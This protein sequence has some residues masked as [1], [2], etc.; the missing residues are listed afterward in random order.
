MAS[1][2][3]WLHGE[4]VGHET[5]QGKEVT[6]STNKDKDANKRVVVVHCK[7]GKG[8]SG[9]VTCSYLIS[10]CGWKAEDAL[11]R[12][13]ERRM[14]PKFGAG[15]SIPSQLRWVSYVDRWTKGGKK[16]VDREIEILEVHVWGLRHG[17]KVAIEGFAEEGKKMVVLHTFNK[18]ERIIIQ[19]DAPG[20]AGIMDFVGDALSPQGDD[21]E[22][23]K[24]E[25]YKAVVNG[26]DRKGRDADNSY[27][28][29]SSASRSSSK[30]R[31]RTSLLLQRNHNSKTAPLST[32][33]KT[34]TIN[35]A[36]YASSETSTP[37]SSN[38]H[39]N[40]AT[41]T[42]SQP[43][44][45]RTNTMASSSEPGGRAV[46][47]KPESPVRVANSDVCVSLE[48]RNRAPA[49]MGL[50]MVT[51]VAHVW[52]NTFFEG[53]GPEQDGKADDSG[54]FE[55]EWEK[56]DGIKGSARKGTKAADK[57][58]V[59]WQA[60]GA[61]GASST[62]EITPGM[63]VT[64]PGKGSP[65]PQMKPA[66][67]HGAD[68]GDPDQGKTLGLRTA[69]PGSEAV[70]KASSIQSQEGHTST[71]GAGGADG[72]AEGHELSDD[73]SLKGV[74]SSGPAGEAEL[75]HSS[76]DGHISS[77]ATG[78]TPVPGHGEVEKGEE[79]LTEHEKKV[80]ATKG[81]AQDPEAASGAAKSREQL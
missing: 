24:E 41:P 35:P 14:R 79:E 58:S 48:R 75:D 19:G 25:D 66:D 71:T 36:D 81:H 56:M 15:V 43:S 49:Y 18:K 47:F 1:M 5:K 27:S 51:A 30:I 28:S 22:T 39:L 61:Q 23:Y 70:S 3:N 34:K 38:A 54:V 74:K 4:D 59:V 45:P 55:I 57:I 2:R 60:V 37:A 29:T 16:Y 8:R 11:A 63:V 40:S 50:T 68:P 72:A 33:T 26:E 64:E 7:A 6:Q 80:E 9:T 73:E 65:V 76:G 21:N 53:N 62:L 46:I 69:D 77:A 10:Q 13:T 12:F 52:F 31:S 67:W 32:K 17:V 44:L 78:F 42:S 20:G